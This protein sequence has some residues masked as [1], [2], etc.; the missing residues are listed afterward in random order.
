MCE[1]VRT[2]LMCIYFLYALVLLH[3]LAFVIL[4]IFNFFVI[5]R[6]HVCQWL[7]IGD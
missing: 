2:I 3:W 6:M 7:V 4:N 5:L 1:K